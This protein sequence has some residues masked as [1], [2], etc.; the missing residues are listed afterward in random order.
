MYDNDDTWYSQPPTMPRYP[1]R[2]VEA[3]GIDLHQTE[4]PMQTGKEPHFVKLRPGTL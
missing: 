3:L 2:V 1:D 4:L